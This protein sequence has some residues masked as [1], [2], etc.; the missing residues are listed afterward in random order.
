M[1]LEDQL[2][3]IQKLIKEKLG[4]LPKNAFQNKTVMKG[5]FRRLYQ[6]LPRMIRLAVSE[7]GFVEFCMEN[8]ERLLNLGDA[9]SD[10][11]SSTKTA[12]STESDAQSFQNNEL[13]VH[14]SQTTA[15]M[16][17]T[18]QRV[19]L[20]TYAPSLILCRSQGAKVWD[21][22]GQEYIDFGAGISVNSLGHQDPELL[23]AL[24]EQ[25][26]KLWHTTNLYLTEPV[27]KLAEE[28]GVDVKPRI[29]NIKISEPATRQKGVM[30]AD[31]A[32][33]VQ[34]LKYEAKV[35]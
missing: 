31:V 29:E 28:L 22:D 5:A 11:F 14:K 26:G 19:F 25:S 12:D 2:P 33:L 27:I 6:A 20:P 7:Q 1:L 18:A 17:A 13:D 16:L 24:T 34:K 35:I 21:R 4:P 9:V 15:D 30:V 32:E 3:R 8:R 10:N 23:H